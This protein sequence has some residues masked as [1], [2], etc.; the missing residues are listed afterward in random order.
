MFWCYKVVDEKGKNYKVLPENYYEIKVD[1][2]KMT[3]NGAP[4]FNEYY[5]VKEKLYVYVRL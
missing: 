3:T 5:V 4:I 1:D 2:Y